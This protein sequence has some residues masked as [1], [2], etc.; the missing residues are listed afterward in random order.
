V[1]DGVLVVDDHELLA[2]SLSLALQA[3]GFDVAVVAPTGMD[4]VLAAAR[5]AQPA[6][7][8]LDLELGDAVGSALPLIAPLRAGGALVV[9]V[10]GI[11]DRIRL[12]ECLEAG[13]A[14]L[15]DKSSSFLQLV[16]AVREVAELG[17]LLSP[18]RRQDLL[19]ELRRQRAN[20][21]RRLQP[22]RRL[23]PREAEVLK[24]LMD[25]QQ[26]EAIATTSFVSLATVRSQIRSVLTKLNVNSQLA[27]VAM[28]RREGWPEPP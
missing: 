25:G 7:V 28:A 11:T 20:R 21:T 4:A 10:T 3:E 24:A 5:E 26:A 2:Q 27:A 6:V 19:A 9:I 22:F 12:A 1:T 8:L 14:G 23:T 17:T 16:D 13:A 18:G 15:L